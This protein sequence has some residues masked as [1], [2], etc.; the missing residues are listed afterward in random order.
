MAIYPKTPCRGLELAPLC[1]ELAF[2]QAD[3]AQK[4]QHFPH[5]L[6]SRVLTS[7]VTLSGHRVLLPTLVATLL[8][9]V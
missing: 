5:V 9:S 4:P 7:L 6:G 8:A 2:L 3:Q 1:W